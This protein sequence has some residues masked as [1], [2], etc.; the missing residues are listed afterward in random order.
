MNIGIS[1]RSNIFITPPFTSTCQ[2][3]MVASSLIIT[4]SSSQTKSWASKMPILVPSTSGIFLD[5]GT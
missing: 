2:P 1:K 3:I 4:V 5:S